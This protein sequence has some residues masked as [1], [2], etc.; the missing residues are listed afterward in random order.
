[1]RNIIGFDAEMEIYITL[2]WKRLYIVPAANGIL[3]DIVIHYTTFYRTKDAKDAAFAMWLKDRDE[4]RIQAY[5]EALTSPMCK[6]IKKIMIFGRPGS[7]KSTFALAL[8]KAT[9]LPL[10][11]LDKH[12]FKSHWVER[13]TDEF[14]KIQR[15]IL[16]KGAWI[17]DGNNIK[18]LEMRYAKADL[19]LYFNYPRWLCYMRIIKRLWD[20]NVEIDDRAPACKETIHLKLLR[21]MWSF[22]ERVFETLKML[23]KK[24]PDTRFIEIRNDEELTLLKYVL[25]MDDR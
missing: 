7:G 6:N 15:S 9:N 25:S 1:M 8:Q 17:I 10:H 23:K 4:K 14:L 20:K 21:Y 24:Y 5:E 19:V 22:E 12:F 3:L 13:E 16:E 11:H 18:S 2:P